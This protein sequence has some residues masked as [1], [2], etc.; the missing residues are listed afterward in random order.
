[1]MR[2]IVT[3]GAGFIGSH[4]IEAL[5]ERGDEVVCVER[6]GAERGWLAGAAIEWAPVGLDDA[7]ALKDI[8][9]GAD[10]VF[11]LA[12]LTQ[13]RSPADYYR[14]NAEGTAH[15]LEAAAAQKRAPRVILLSS[16]AALGPCRNGDRLSRYTVPYPLSHYG[17][18]KLVAEATVH[19]HADRVPATV[20]RLASVY[21]PRERAVLAMFRLVR[22]GLAVTV[23]GWDREVSLIYVKDVVGALLAVADTA[24]AIG[25]TYCVAHPDPVRWSDF[26]REVGRAL[27]REPRLVSVPVGLAR[28]IARTAELYAAARHTAAIF[29]RERLREMS[30][31]RWVCDPAE[32]IA[33]TGYTPQYPITRGVPETATWYEK[34]GWL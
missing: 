22:R 8:V 28:P 21:G 17:L 2:A 5:L 9:R 13:A 4:L 34:A 18:S 33:D 15:V 1:M 32:L 24:Q 23:G 30:Q 26:A 16:L 27:A 14:V 6:R 10:V 29:N 20:L 11:H 19:A 12:G 3:G 31:E 25:R 7:G